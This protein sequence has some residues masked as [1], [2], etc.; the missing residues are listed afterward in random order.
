MKNNTK[1]MHKSSVASLKAMLHICAIK[2]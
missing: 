1:A 2:Y